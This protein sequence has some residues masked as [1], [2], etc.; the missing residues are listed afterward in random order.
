MVAASC[1]WRRV[2]RLCQVES[3]QVFGQHTPGGKLKNWKS[4]KLTV[5]TP[6][7]IAKIPG[8]QNFRFSLISATPR[9][10]A[11]WAWA[12]W[13]CERPKRQVYAHNRTFSH[14]LYKHWLNG[15]ERPIV[16]VG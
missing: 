6:G 7:Q 3:A 8:F 15:K 14:G 11:D 1:P 5:C 16:A 9:N 10:P 12:G 13:G 2:R 4:E